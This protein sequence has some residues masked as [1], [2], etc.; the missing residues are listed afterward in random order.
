MESAWCKL[1]SRPV[2]SKRFARNV[3]HTFICD[4]GC[5]TV[6]PEMYFCTNRRFI[7]AHRK[8]FISFSLDNIT[9]LWLV[10]SYSHVAELFP[11]QH[12][13]QYATVLKKIIFK[14]HGVVILLEVFVD[15]AAIQKSICIKVT[16]SRYMG[17]R[18]LWNCVSLRQHTAVWCV[19]TLCGLQME[20]MLYCAHS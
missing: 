18:W 16:V 2:S 5:Y 8:T 13:F 19:V 20:Q 12:N 3:P 14:I 6:C 4:T 17:A 11:F 9:Q 7:M 1:F 10:I 15:V